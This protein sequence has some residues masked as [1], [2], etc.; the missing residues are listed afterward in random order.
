[1]NLVDSSGWLSYLLDEPNAGRFVQSIV[2]TEEL[3][4][5][6]IVVLEVYRHL[7]RSLGIETA[8]QAVSTLIDCQT[9]DLTREIAILAGEL[10]IRY[11]LPL[12]DSVVLATARSFNAILWTQDSD[13]EGLENVEYIPRC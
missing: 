11:K 8:A 1:M 5:P 13:F 2:N 10:G 12:A 3:I 4:V 9:V 6:S 7:R